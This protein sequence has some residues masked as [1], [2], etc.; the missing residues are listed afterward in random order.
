MTIRNE[1]KRLEELGRMPDESEDNL[2]SELLNLYASLLH[3]IEKP[4]NRE[5]AKILIRLFPE[6]GLFGAEWT[7][8][9]LFETI[10]SIEEDEYI[11]LI[12]EC[13]SKEWRETLTARLENRKTNNEDKQ[14]KRHDK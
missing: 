13:P 8:L 10:F 6:S 11:R 1:I 9:H 12:A 4:V 7:L 14:I 2:S 3:S 5:E